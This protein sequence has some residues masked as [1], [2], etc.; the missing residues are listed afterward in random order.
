[1]MVRVYRNLHKNCWSVQSKNEK[2]SWIVTA[3][4]ESVFLRGVTF[5]VSQAGYERVLREG[6]KNV[7]A[8][9][10]GQWEEDRD[11]PYNT[12]EYDELIRYS[13]RDRLGANF[14]VS[15]AGKTVN[16]AFHAELA[17]DGRVYSRLEE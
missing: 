10:Y 2:G 9:V 4:K 7:H 1:M 12:E 13:P 11:P 8:Y 5:K 17:K 3:H 6:R 16:T 14:R 15:P